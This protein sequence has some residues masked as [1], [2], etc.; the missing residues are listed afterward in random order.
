MRYLV[1]G[2]ANSMHIFN[3]TKT[4]LLPLK[5]EV[6][7]LTLSVEPI[8]ETY[9]TFYREHGVTVHSVAEKCY[10]NLEKKDRIHR[11]LN[12]IR[13]F[14]LMND[15]PKVD[16]CHVQSVYKTSLMMVLCNREKFDK[17]ILSYWGGDIEDKSKFVV[18]LREKC[19]KF[20]NA[21]T[22]TVKQNYNKFRE[23]YGDRYDDKLTICRFATEGLQCIHDISLKQTRESCRK[24]YGIPEGKICI[25]CGYSA[26]A[27]QHQEYCLQEINKLDEKFKEKLFVIVP[28]QYGRYDNIYIEK[29]HNIAQKCTFECK[30]LEEFVPFEISAQLALATDIYIHVRDTDAFSNALK[31]HV[32]AGSFV[33]KG[34]WLQ[35]FE[36]DEMNA[37]I[38][39]IASLSELKKKLTNVLETFSISNEYNLFPPIYELYSTSAIAEQWD[40]VIR[41]VVNVNGVNEGE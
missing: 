31:E 35:Y 30:I 6:H 36:L 20:A 40:A 12:L 4:V 28:M 22:V 17:L 34:D 14:K 18:K 39:S 27:E 21:I 26:Y 8:R 13:K 9:R 15:V 32:Y 24:T 1:I 10:R 37:S 3:F 19:F 38:D 5:Y 29:V 16:I 11:L 33:I 2:D 25:T 23:M 7:L 41:S